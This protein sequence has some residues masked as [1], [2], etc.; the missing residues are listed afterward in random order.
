MHIAVSSK[1][2]VN[3]PKFIH[4]ATDTVNKSIHNSVLNDSLASEGYIFKGSKIHTMTISTSCGKIVKCTNCRKKVF[5][6]G[7]NRGSIQRVWS[8]MT[9]ELFQLSRQSFCYVRAINFLYPPELRVMGRSALTEAAM[10]TRGILFSNATTL[11]TP[12][13]GVSRATLP[14]VWLF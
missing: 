2:Y 14:T 4:W 6:R 1:H 5:S 13:G 10:C 8:F 11:S 7:T 12:I 9:C 3:M